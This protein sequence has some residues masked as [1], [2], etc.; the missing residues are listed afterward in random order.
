MNFEWLYESSM[1]RRSWKDREILLQ[2]KCGKLVI[3]IGDTEWFSWTLLKIQNCT[4]PA[5]KNSTEWQTTTD[6]SES[7]WFQR[8]SPKAH[9]PGKHTVPV[10]LYF[11]HPVSSVCMMQIS[12]LNIDCYPA[13]SMWGGIEQAFGSCHA[14]ADDK[15]YRLI[16]QDSHPDSAL[17][18]V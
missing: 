5:I 7:G 13:G 3:T 15:E 2:R 14:G 10:M 4:R 16:A 18:W 11:N 1:H 17:G 9:N 12:L 6:L 8:A